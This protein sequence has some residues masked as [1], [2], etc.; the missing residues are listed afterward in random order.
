MTDDL[1]LSDLESCIRRDPA[2]RGLISSEAEF[3]PICQ[4]HFAAAVQSLS[5]PDLKIAIAT[6]FFVPG[7]KPPSAE[8]DGPPGAIR[9]A[10]ALEA[11]G[12]QVVIVTDS[13]CASALRV[14]CRIAEFPGEVCELDGE[15]AS[16]AEDAVLIQSLGNWADRLIAIERVG[17]SHTETSISEQSPDRHVLERFLEEV[18]E[19]SRGHCHNMRG[20]IITAVT[21]GVHRLFEWV[22]KQ[23]PEVTTIAIGDGGNEIG[24]G[25]LRWEDVTRRLLGAHA[26]KIVCRI[27]TDWN[28]IAGTSNWGGYALAA[29]ILAAHDRLYVMEGWTCEAEE[30]LLERFV[31]EGPMVDGATRLP[32]ATVDGL[33]FI[34]YIQPWAAIR[35]RLGLPE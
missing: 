25:C 35:R 3:G 11:I 29:A 4:G 34:T 30:R 21:G 13:H 19:G 14:A 16:E 33:P 15:E 23:R 1:L 18:P 9:L 8:T 12:H 28:I 2:M 22:Q 27:A 6:G 7:A 24:M 26:A 32:E 20:E 5:E 17:P 31:A 10:L